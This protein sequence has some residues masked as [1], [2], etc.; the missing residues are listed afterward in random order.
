MI[1][2]VNRYFVNRGNVST[3]KSNSLEPIIAIG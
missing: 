1:E 2:L 3:T